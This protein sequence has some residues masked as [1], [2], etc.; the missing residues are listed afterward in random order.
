MSKPVPVLDPRDTAAI[1]SQLIA[2]VP[3]YLP[4]W[5]GVATGTDAP[6][7]AV[8]EVL[9][10]YRAIFAEGLNGAPARQELAFLETLGNALLAGQPARVPLVFELFST[11]PQDVFLPARSQVAAK[12]PPPPA[13][14][15][16]EI[17]ASA[18][19]R[20]APRFFT[21]RTVALSRGRVAALYSTDP[22][23][24]AY[25]DHLADKSTGFVVF[26]NLRAAPH[27]MYFGQDELFA[28]AGAAE[29][30]L[31]FDMAGG[32]FNDRLLMLEWEYLST[33]GWLPL[34]V[35]EDTTRRLTVDG[36]V[37]LRKRC[38]P[39]AKR[40][41]VNG[42]ESF[43]I[44]ARAAEGPARARVVDVLT[45]GVLL[46]RAGA[47]QPGDWVTIDG[48][49]KERVISARNRTITFERPL[50]ELE[51]D[52]VIRVVDITPPLGAATE[53]KLGQPTL[54]DM[55]RARVGFSKTELKPD[56]AFADRVTLDLDNVFFP[57]S[58]QPERYTTFYLACDE[59]FSRAGAA[60]VLDVK[61][62]TA[63]TVDA[64]TVLAFEYY[65]GTSWHELS[66]SLPTRLVD[67]TDMFQ[68]SGTIAFTAPD[69]WAAVAVHGQKQFWMRVRIDAGGYGAPLSL[70]VVNDSSGNPQVSAAPS[71][72]KPP[73]IASLRAAYT[74]ST[75]SRL[76]DRCLAY[77]NFVFRD[78]SEDCRWTRRPFAPMTHNVERE[79][80][81]HLG[82]DQKL[83]P[84][85]ISL[86][87]DVDD[88]GDADDEGAT[89]P[90]IWEYR[91]AEGWAELTV[92]D[93]TAGLRRQGMIQF[94]GPSDAEAIEGL[95]GK[96][97]RIRAR[98]KSG[99]RLRAA[100]VRSLWSNAVW[101]TQGEA[102]TREI[103][104]RSDGNPDQVLSVP[105]QRVPVLAGE[106]V[107]VRE[108]SGRG[109]SWRTAVEGVPE[110]DLR[111]DR[112]PVTQAPRAVWVRWQ[113]REHLLESGPDDRHY[114]LERTR[115][116][117]QFGDDTHARIPP[118]GA[119]VA[120][121]FT[122]GIGE[123]G[124]VPAR[125]I[126]ELRTGAAY[127]QGVNNPIAADGGAAPEAT[128]AV[129]DRATFRLR[130]RQ[131]AIAPDDYEWLAHEASPA[132]AR[133]RSLRVCGEHGR[134]MPGA[135]TVVIVPR[136]GTRHP[137]PSPELRRQVRDHLA[138]FCP[139]TVARQ[140]RVIG[141]SYV[142]VGVVAHVV[143]A[144]VEAVTTVEAALRR[145]LDAW[146]HPVT[147]GD[148]GRGWPFG[149]SLCLSTVA[150]LIETLPGLDH[151]TRVA[152]RA[153]GA[154]AGDVLRLPPDALPAAGSHEVKIELLAR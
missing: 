149:A 22:R 27:E 70:S 21:T 55:I 66:T 151:A 38:G 34:D 139:P 61:L 17:E 142:E 83:P 39:D 48:E 111:F 146:L 42:I 140:L 24:D 154:N 75:Q 46:D 91:T 112:D 16:S 148:D 65:D 50:T 90:F 54:V 71:T 110:A 62:K 7:D 102:V 67:G 43:W 87:V 30:A 78:H 73:G 141:P 100:R 125:T 49:R 77:N 14:V 74:Y 68:H 117:L 153:D 122:T 59:A 60:V 135:V 2:R 133:A 10:R 18:A 5:T 64:G 69:D 51:A 136:G 114:A 104:G 81:V 3:G 121:S 86:F 128:N 36:R 115:G 13:A 37:L 56:R 8:L 72:L 44:R 15:E 33:D 19:T 123:S 97:Y 28:L 105:A 95:G 132:V 31:S 143:L 76:L 99:E 57:F 85:L 35:E 147:G 25:A 98:L 92:L 53:E 144:E 131:R 32:D 47:L 113:A 152:F 80:A 127:V 130:H 120:L 20:E 101:G 29:I 137:Q 126:T 96:L 9:S 12:L 138:R 118:A 58:Q 108:W 93:E 1:A 79:P 89:S 6:G 63:G 107:E 88:S 41:K 134:K 129:V 124:N 106:L 45:Q 109:E 40:D 11:S 150:S 26:E 145:R 103:V 4:R 23:V 52:A 84:G 82:F 94:I 116:R 119:P